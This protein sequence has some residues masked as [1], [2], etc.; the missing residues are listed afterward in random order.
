MRHHQLVDDDVDAPAAVGCA[1]VEPRGAVEAVEE[2][3]TDISLCLEERPRLLRG[4][5]SY[6]EV[7][8]GVRPGE[9]TAANA[10][11]GEPDGHATEQLDGHAGTGGGGG[12]ANALVANIGHGA[13]RIVGHGVTLLAM[14]SA[15]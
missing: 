12:Q 13:G 10:R 3:V 6:G 4:R 9:R 1:V 11:A 15:T 7:H 14:L 2:L 5:C 8:I